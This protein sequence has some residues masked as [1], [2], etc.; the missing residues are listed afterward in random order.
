M[1]KDKA[2]ERPATSIHYR[3]GFKRICIFNLFGKRYF[4]ELECG[5]LISI[6]HHKKA[7]FVVQKEDE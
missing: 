2:D 5:E 6:V 4:L 7:V 1:T 3:G